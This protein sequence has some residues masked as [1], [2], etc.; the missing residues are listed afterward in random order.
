MTKFDWR[1]DLLAGKTGWFYRLLEM[2]RYLK[3][4]CQLANPA[5]I[6]RRRSIFVEDF[7]WPAVH[8]D[9]I[10]PSVYPPLEL[11]GNLRLVTPKSVIHSTLLYIWCHKIDHDGFLV[12]AQPPKHIKLPRKISNQTFKIFI[13]ESYKAAFEVLYQAASRVRMAIGGTS[14]VGKTYFV[15]YLIW[16]LLHP[17]GVVVVR[18]VE[19]VLLTHHFGGDRRGQLYHQGHFYF[20]GSVRKFLQIKSVKAMFHHK[21]A[22]IIGDGHLPWTMDIVCPTVLISSAA[23]YNLSNQATFETSKLKVYIPPWKFAE[24]V[25]IMTSI[26]GYPKT[27]KTL[28]RIMKAYTA[29]GG[30]PPSII[31]NFKKLRI[32]KVD[33]DDLA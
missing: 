3:K 33:A 7:T 13:R 24:L 5:P 14:G 28:N 29:Y 10:P 31:F 11:P 25:K 23:S 27:P 21:N 18:P 26:H 9:E 1:M 2:D 22:W 4:E 8:L 17:D 6:S 20:V 32:P 30:I 15:R 16:R 19:T 12:P